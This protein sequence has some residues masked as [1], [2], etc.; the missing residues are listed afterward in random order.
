MENKR[1][2]KL[3]QVKDGDVVFI[4]ACSQCGSTAKITFNGLEPAVELSK[5]HKNCGL[6]PL[7]GNG[8]TAQK[9]PGE[10]SFTIEITGQESIDDKNKN[11]KVTQHITVL[12]DK[13]GKEQGF[14]YTYNIEDVDNGDE[15]FNDYYINVVAWH[16]KG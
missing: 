14:C 5:N 10:L 8:S 2:F 11:M 15:D 4:S 7:D 16:N 6:C 3:E 13:D 1:T 9:A 12:T